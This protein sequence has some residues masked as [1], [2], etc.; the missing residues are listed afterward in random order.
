MKTN[1]ILALYARRDVLPQLARR[2]AA[3]PVARPKQAQ[4]GQPGKSQQQKTISARLQRPD[5]QR[6]QQYAQQHFA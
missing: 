6:G 2:L 3:R 1:D 5:A 4:R